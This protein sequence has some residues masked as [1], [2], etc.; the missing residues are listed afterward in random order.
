MES[1]ERWKDYR[2]GGPGGGGGGESAGFKYCCSPRGLQGK[3]KQRSLL[4][5]IAKCL[6][7]ICLFNPL[8]KK[9]IWACDVDERPAA[10]WK[11]WRMGAGCMWARH[12]HRPTHTYNTA[13]VWKH[14]QKYYWWEHWP[15]HW[16]C[17]ASQNSSKCAIIKKPSTQQQMFDRKKSRAQ[18][19][20]RRAITES[21]QVLHFGVSETERGGEGQTEICHCTRMSFQCETDALPA[22]TLRCIR[23]PSHSSMYMYTCCAVYV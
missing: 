5:S 20:S 16:S 17:T 18:S 10:R 7:G 14:M 2:N 13:H 11:S 9:A 15:L 19:S 8:S 6:P 21:Q 3:W 4:W 23:V 12:T 1:R 22:K